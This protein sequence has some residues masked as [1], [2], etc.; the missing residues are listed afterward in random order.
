MT[1]VAWNELPHKT[2]A[3]I[4]VDSDPN[5]IRSQLDQLAITIS[6]Q[7]IEALEVAIKNNE[8][9]IAKQILFDHLLDCIFDSVS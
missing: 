8:E 3:I 7:Q 6:Q 2:R 9:A 5:F 1:T 4:A